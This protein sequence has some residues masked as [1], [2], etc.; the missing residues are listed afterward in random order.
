MAHEVPIKCP[1]CEK[2]FSRTDYRARHVKEVHG[3]GPPTCACGKIIGR[4][5]NLAR[6]MEKCTKI[7]PSL[8][9]GC[10]ARFPMMDAFQAHQDACILT[11]RGAAKAVERKLE[12]IGGDDPSSA[13]RQ[14]LEEVAAEAK[15]KMATTCAGCGGGFTDVKSMGRHKRKFGH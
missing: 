7:A 11:E 2:A 12:E 13:S 9:C 6:H 5:D 4:G 14:A 3:D 1:S 15:A 8:A 10:G